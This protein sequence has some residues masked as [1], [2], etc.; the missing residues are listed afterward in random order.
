KDGM[1]QHVPSGQ[2]L[3]YGALAS[4]AATVPVP[5]DVPLKTS[6]FRLLGGRHRRIDG[7]DVVTGRAV[8]GLDVRLPGM[9][10]AVIAKPPCF[11]AQVKSWSAEAAKRIAGVRGA[12]RVT[13]GYA[14]GVA[15]I[16]DSVWGALEARK[17]LAIEWAKTEDA[18]FSS[19]SHYVELR[20]TLAAR[21]QAFL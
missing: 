4:R 21:E 13:S 16:A 19:E 2:T 8:Y 5:K 15:V 18:S 7:L 12:L 17:A 1:V 11:G 3:A 6:A 9:K 14:E 20:K 10:Y